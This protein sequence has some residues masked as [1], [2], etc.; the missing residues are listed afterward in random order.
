[1]HHSC[2]TG[3][4]CLLD[5]VVRRL[6]LVPYFVIPELVSNV[7]LQQ[8]PRFQTYNVGNYEPMKNKLILELP[9]VSSYE[10]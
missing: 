4:Y 2:N 1:M 8:F 3:Q 10:S 6:I 7:P 9:L 5:E